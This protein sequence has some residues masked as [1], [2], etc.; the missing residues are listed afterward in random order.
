[1]NGSLPRSVDS[2]STVQFNPGNGS[3]SNSLQRSIGKKRLDSSS[4]LNSVGY[5]SNEGECV[6]LCFNFVTFHHQ[7]SS[8]RRSSTAGSMLSPVVTQVSFF[9]HRHP[10]P[11]RS[12]DQ[13]RWASDTAEFMLFNREPFFANGFQFFDQPTCLLILQARLRGYVHHLSFVTVDLF[14]QLVLSASGFLFHGA[15][16]VAVDFRFLKMSFACI[17]KVSK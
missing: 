1:M 12:Q 2:S 14:R 5:C 6:N 4:D 16:K 15:K 11:T 17:W 3:Q 10:P 13:R 9:G 8:H 7:H